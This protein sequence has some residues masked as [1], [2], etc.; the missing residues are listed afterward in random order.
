MHVFKQCTCCDFSWI[1]REEFLQDPHLEL[2][3]YQVNFE[4]LKLGYF[5]FNHLTCESTI[6]V[7]AGRFEDLYNGPVFSERLTGYETCPGYCL[8]QDIL[9][10][11]NALCE[12]AYV[13]EIVQIIRFWPKK[14]I[15]PVAADRRQHP[16]SPACILP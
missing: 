14:E 3:G 5:L 1:S 11:C 10:P 4:N 8:H 9:Q 13:R 2:I 12:C 15:Q 7:P 6:A 16:S